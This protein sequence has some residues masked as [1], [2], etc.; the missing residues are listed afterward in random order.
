MKGVKPNKAM[1]RRHDIIREIGCIVCLQGRGWC[2]PQI[3]HIEGCRTQ[4]AHAKTIGLCYAHHM[5]DQRIIS[6]PHYYIS[7]HPNKKAFENRYGTEQELLEH[8][9][10]LIAEHTQL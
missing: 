9:N 7:R 4:E 10:S 6:Y 2:P 3:H 1:K 5:A 8:Q